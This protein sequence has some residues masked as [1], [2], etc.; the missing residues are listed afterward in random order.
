MYITQINIFR[1][2]NI[3]VILRYN[4][5][6]HV[7]RCKLYV[8]GCMTESENKYASVRSKTNMSDRLNE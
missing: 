2:K 6:T 8:G 4:L 5:K 1:W 7:T 3:V